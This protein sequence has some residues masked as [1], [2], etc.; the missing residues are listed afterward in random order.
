MTIPPDQL[1][2]NMTPNPE[3]EGKRRSTTEERRR[4]QAIAATIARLARAAGLEVTEPGSVDPLAT[5]NEARA[6]AIKADTQPKLLAFTRTIQQSSVSEEVQTA[7]Q[8]G[9]LT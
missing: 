6:E 3:D 5:P 4:Q 9:G 2:F 7:C 1:L 8:S